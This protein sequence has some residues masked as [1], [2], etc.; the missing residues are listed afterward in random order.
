MALFET[1]MTPC[2]KV[3]RGR[4]P[5]GEGGWT[6]GWVDGEQ[7]DAAIVLDSSTGARIAEATGYTAAYTV[8]T[9]RGLGLAFH[10][11]FRRES[12]DRTF[13]VVKV[14]DPTPDVASFQFDQYQCEEWGLA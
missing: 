4:V 8:T 6:T 12:D 7:F 5:D 14:C 11:A 1:F 2:T 10:D 9:A 13:R 3:E